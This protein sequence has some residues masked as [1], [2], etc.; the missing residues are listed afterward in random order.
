MRAQPLARI[1]DVQRGNGLS[2]RHQHHARSFRAMNA[3]I[4]VLHLQG[5][6]IATSRSRA[7]SRGAVC[8]RGLST[9]S[10]PAGLTRV[11]MPVQ[12]WRADE[13][14]ILPAPDDADAVRRALPRPPE[15]HAVRGAG[16]F[17]FLVPCTAADIAP[18]ICRSR[19]G[20]DRAAFHHVFNA[21][22]VRFCLPSWPARA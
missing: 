4:M 7:S 10:M 14:E 2:Q 8:G 1:F 11:T 5:G 13:D 6:D 12:L 18:K 21:R 16:H 15:F 17:D 22:L 3:D 9:R 19:P 20:F